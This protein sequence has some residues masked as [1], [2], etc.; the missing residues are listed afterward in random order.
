MQDTALLPYLG[1]RQAVEDLEAF[2]QALSIDRFWLYGESYGTQFAQTYAA[3]HP[4]RL[5]G[6][7]LDGTVDLT[8]TGAEFARESALAFER[9]L[10]DTLAACAADE[11]CAADVGS[12][13]AGVYDALASQLARTPLGIKFPRIEGEPEVRLFTRADL[14]TAAAGYL[15]APDARMILLRAL[16][17]A[18]HGDLA[19]LARL[20]YSSLGADPDTQEVAPDPTYSDAA[21]YAVTCSDYQTFSG[22][23]E[24]RAEAYLRAGDGIAVLAPRM[25]ALFYGDLPCAFWPDGTA[26]GERPAPLAAEGI[27]ALVLGATAD[28]LTPLENGLRVYR[29]LADGYHITTLGGSHVMF[30]RGEP[31]PD[32]LVTAFLAD[33]QLPAERETTCENALID[34]YAPVAPV[35]AR[36]FRDPLEALESFVTEAR[37]LPEFYYWDGAA[38]VTAA[39]A[40]GGNLSFEPKGNEARL[41]LRACA[42]SAGFALTGGGEYDAALDRFALQVEVS[43]WAKGSLEFTREG[44]GRARVTGTYGGRKVDLEREAP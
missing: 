41:V 31:C 35:N 14:D 6:L 29:R 28:P 18:A 32:D 42:F 38:P 1:T 21:Y 7:I 3:A 11:A 17:S 5:A 44:D 12:D 40:W 37:Y 4:D 36:A 8:L 34:A 39:C 22:A 13:P 20:L 25:G 15:S 43:G 23:P 26:D 2:R 30:G 19:P 10:S 9:V 33:G 27:P 24:E 16:A